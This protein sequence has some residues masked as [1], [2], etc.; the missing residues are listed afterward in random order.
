MNW[1]IRTECLTW[2]ARNFNRDA[3]LEIPFLNQLETGPDR[4]STITSSVKTG[5]LIYEQYILKYEQYF[6][7]ELLF[8]WWDPS[9]LE[10]HNCGWKKLLLDPFSLSCVH[11]WSFLKVTDVT[12]VTVKRCT[13]L[14]I[15]Y[16]SIGCFIYENGVSR[17]E[18]LLSQKTA[19]ML[20]VQ[21]AGLITWD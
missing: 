2:T 1:K 18:V 5:I 10:W 3:L 6:S 14:F 21:V 13:I 17:V 8:C 20:S 7:D 12:K 9:K 16:V 11:K 15:Q 19:V 4:P